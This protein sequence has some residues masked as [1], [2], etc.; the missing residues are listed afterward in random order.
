VHTDREG[1]AAHRLTVSDLRQVLASKKL[2]YNVLQTHQSSV[3]SLGKDRD[4]ETWCAGTIV[5]T[6]T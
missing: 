3:E 4:R 2:H 5:I 1:Q 6:N